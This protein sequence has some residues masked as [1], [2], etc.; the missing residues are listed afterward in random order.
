MTVEIND[1]DELARCIIFDRAFEN[2]IHVDELLWQFGATKADGASHESAVLRRLAPYPEDVHRIGCRIA[3]F[4]NERKGN[5]PPGPGRRYYCGFREASFASLPKG[6]DGYRIEYLNVPENGE[7]AHVD[8][9]LY[10]LVEGRS[11]KAV[12]RTEAGLAIA[13]HFGPPAPHQCEVDYEDA[14]HPFALYGRDCLVSGLRD[15]WPSLS[16]QE[17]SS[18]SSSDAG[19]SVPIFGELG[20]GDGEASPL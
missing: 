7:K 13:E 12:R 5:P 16:L 1:G 19:G 10:I 3:A 4:Q 17:N 9:A 15:R 6:G 20:F 18:V 8:V 2:D 11:A 14:Q